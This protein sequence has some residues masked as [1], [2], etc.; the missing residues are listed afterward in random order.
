[1]RNAKSRVDPDYEQKLAL[2]IHK[3]FVEKGE[4]ESAQDEF[5]VLQSM[6]NEWSHKQSEVLRSALIDRL[7]VRPEERGYKVLREA[8]KYDARVS[9]DVFMQFMEWER[10]PEKR[11]YMPRRRIIKSLWVDP[12]QD[13]LDGK[14]DLLS[15]ST[16]PGTGKS[17]IGNFALAFQMGKEPDKP[18]LASAHSG[19]LTDSFY[20]SVMSL[21]TD[22]EYTY[23]EIFPHEIADKNGM[24]QTI[25]LVKPHRFSTLT[26]RA[27]NASLTGAT[28]CEGLLYA[29]D[30]V[31]GIEEAMN[32]DRL[33]NLWQKY[34]NDLKSRKKDGVVTEIDG[35]PVYTGCKELHIATRW[36][37]RDVIGRLE[38]LYDENPRC[39]FIRCPALNDNDESNFD[40]DY[41]VGF[42]TKYFIDM[43]KNLDPVSWSALFVNEPIER[44]GLMFPRDDLQY[45]SD[46]P[47][48]ENGNVL[49]PDYRFAIADTKDKGADYG[50]MPIVWVYGDMGYVVHMVCDNGKP[51]VVEAKF[52]DAIIKYKVQAC[53]FESNAAGGKIADKI[54][55]ELKQRGYFCNITRKFTTA[56]KETKIQVNSPQIKQRFLF[57]HNFDKTT[58]YGMA[59]YM[60][61]TYVLAGKN[62]H[63]DVPD[64]MSMANEFWD[65]FTTRKVQIIKRPF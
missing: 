26:C 34:T 36:S 5:M 2:A 17:T 31:S 64:G 12:I 52:V 9:F 7:R 49:E 39:K 24:N 6:G 46:I 21:I 3:R 20:R 40:Y 4:F 57:K 59:M 50:F 28:R 27:I 23:K 35:K 63:D 56:N 48:D 54:N 13:L 16:P 65:S 60:L 37:V 30:L 45:Y 53:R 38:A 33:D 10:D 41:G 15:I 42:S 44:K 22:P 47:V 29:D 1:M 55:S 61:T 62:K 25:D 51:E 8:L 18:N 19:T 43:R 14:L 32:P 11:F 58:E